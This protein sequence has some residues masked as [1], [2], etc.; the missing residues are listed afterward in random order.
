MHGADY[1]RPRRSSFSLRTAFWG[2]ALLACLCILPR[3]AKGQCNPSVASLTVS[4]SSI[5][6]LST[7]ATGTVT[8][9]CA[10]A[11]NTGVFLSNNS[12]G[13]LIASNPT[14]SA[15][16]TTATF[17]YT[18]GQVAQ[19]TT[20]SVGATT[21]NGGPPQ[22]QA[23]LTVVPLTPTL[24]VSPSSIIA[25]SGQATLT[26]SLNGTVRNPGVP[27]FS[28]VSINIASSP[29]PNGLQI[30][31]PS[32]S[33]IVVIPEGSSTGTLTAGS[34]QVPQATTYTLT[35]I[36]QQGGPSAQAAITVNPLIA[37][38]TLKP[39]SVLG[40]QQVTLTVTLNAAPGGPAA[41]GGVTVDVAVG[42]PFFVNPAQTSVGIPPGITT[43]TATFFTVAITQPAA[44]PFNVSVGGVVTGSATLTILPPGPPPPTDNGAD[45]GSPKA[46]VKNCGG[47]INLTTGNTWIQER[48]YSLPGLGGGLELVRTWNSRW[49]DATNIGAA[50]TFGH[51]WR[52]TYDERLSFLDSS[53]LKYWRADGSGWTFS[54]N[55]AT[56]TYALSTPP[57]ERAS[58]VLDSVS[59]QF[60]LTLADG[61][62]RLFSQPGLLVALLDRNGN[63]VSVNYD[64]SKRPTQVSDA[65]GRSI[66]FSYSDP[67][68]TSQATSIQD[69]VGVV[70]TYAY[71][72]SARLTKVTYSDGSS[73]NF[74]YDA[75][76]LIAS[77]TDGQGKLLESH[78]YDSQHRGL[79]SQ[80]ALLADSITLTYGT[81]GQTQLSDSMGNLSS[82]GFQAI[83]GRNFPTSVAGPGC[84]SCGGRGNNSFTY[85]AQGNQRSSTDA[86]GRTTSFTYDSNGNVLTRSIQLNA[87]T[88]L[89][90]SFT[91]NQFQQVLTATDP[92]GNTTTNTYDARGN[93]LSTTIPQGGT[94][95]TTNFAYDAKGE[96]TQVTDP[97]G[98]A[99]TIAY[100]PAGLVSST[101]DAQGNSTT[102]TYDARGNR[103]QVTDALLN[104]TSF[105][106][107]ALNRLTQI[108]QPGN[109]TTTF[110][111]DPR[112]RR[113]SVVDASGKTT[114]YQYDDA[115]RLLAVTDAAANVTS[116]Q[117]DTEN[118]LASITD[119]LGRVT[120]FSYD[121][122]G[123]VTGVTFPSTLAETY[124]YDAVGNLLTKKDRKSQTISYAY[125]NLDRLTQK[126][127]PDSTAVSYTYDNLSRLTQAADPSGTYT[128]AY[129]NLGRLT[130]TTS[131]Y[132][133]LTGR[134]LTN[135]YTYDAASNRLALTDPEGG[136]TSYTYDTL[137]RLTGLTDFK[138]SRL[139]FS[140][141][142]LGRRT[143]LS[144]PNS[145]ITNYQYDSL[146]RLL[147]VLHQIGSSTID[148]A[149][150]T[151]DAVGNRT[152]KTNLLQNLPAGDAPTSNYAYDAIYQ[153]TQAAQL[154]TP[155]ES[156]TYDKV[157]NRLSSLGVAS[158]SYNA[159]NELTAKGPNASFTYDANGNTLSK[160]DIAGTTTYTWDFENRLTSVTLPTGVVVNF[161]YDPF[162]RRTLRSSPTTTRLFVYDG[163]NVLERLNG[164]G[165]V[166]VR[167]TM[168]LG[169]DEPLVMYRDGQTDFYE[170]DGLGSVTSM[171]DPTGALANSY[172]YDSFGRM[173]GLSETVRNPLRYTARE[174]DAE[175][176]LYYYR[177]R[178][179][180]PSVGRFLSEDPVGLAGGNNFYQ[181]AGNR[182][183]NFTDPSGQSASQ[184]SDSGLAMIAATMQRIRAL[185][186][187]DP[188]CLC[189]LGSNKSDPLQMLD[190]ILRLDLF[191]MTPIPP[192]T[193]SQG[194]ITSIVNAETASG[195]PNQAVTV[196][197]LGAFFNRS[198]NG[199]PLTTNNGNIAG[200]TA[201][202]QGFI[203][204]HEL[205]HVTQVLLPDLHNAKAEA[206]NNK[207][208]AKHCKKTIKALG[209][210]Q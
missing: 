32:G 97:L 77:V 36:N 144:R 120:G 52:S 47:P 19:M 28:G 55:S 74:A 164:T 40:G 139:T 30:N 132:S 105:T 22:A 195:I 23:P 1:S 210:K 183:T 187:L 100:T 21:Q 116:Y 178:Y 34:G 88:T 202:A 190:D 180:D 155:K 157:G 121:P 185:L 41:L 107:D 149:S 73:L 50:G 45:N 123:R 102:F 159:S 151:Y 13:V 154:G 169:I 142:A 96:L 148:G 18:A 197:S 162:G 138:A 160:T 5:I 207:D 119:A 111:Y 27:F 99:T 194:N 12:N 81:G 71:D 179:Y 124:T 104:K 118:H 175:A 136:V 66:T 84:S 49:Q 65:A 191:G 39:T 192:E 122:L 206:Q 184:N 33:N 91:Y 170:A 42:P 188:K 72:A 129:D 115:D 38:P 127:F 94:G 177:A 10:P 7:A 134:T 83:G 163:D 133:F 98:H 67:A 25:L 59:N 57:D 147:S 128:F 9:T 80:R 112:G 68:N 16:S 76:S 114:A 92:L 95:L 137:N 35:A 90:W 106:Y 186:P 26:V 69:S 61:T 108:V 8:L 31:S 150:Y 152:V 176:G 145:V 209:E 24:T 109:L 172:E 86:L 130:G 44:E 6:S 51:S 198:L 75:S 110:T 78:T 11:V 17:Q 15:G 117:Y 199:V 131:N 156:Y 146:S 48:D 182:P 161:Q 2:L 168:G 171:S 70:A 196:N 174:H 153:L 43:G 203:I 166:V 181:Y 208:I 205:G 63:Q 60:T 173:L 87:T 200:G 204:L 53:T 113:I 126:T 189:F 56:N 29:S 3:P 201:R 64:A 140:Y 167:F 79:S 14:V 103:T 4:P 85:D 125:D 158:Y 20:F 54:F 143:S 141:D 93:L 82:Y 37:T 58:L 46:C 62:K 101:T 135:S 89:T 165:A 193:D